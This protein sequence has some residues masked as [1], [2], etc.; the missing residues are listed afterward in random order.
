MSKPYWTVKGNVTKF[1][2][3]EEAQDVVN[4]IGKLGFGKPPVT[5]HRMIGSLWVRSTW[6][7]K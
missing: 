6:I 1:Y 4:E 2:N 5:Y 7:I 3:F